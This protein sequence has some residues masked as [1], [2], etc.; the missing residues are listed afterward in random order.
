M[1]GISHEIKCAN[2]KHVL[3]VPVL[4]PCSHS[5]C[6]KHTIATEEPILCRICKKEHQ[7]PPPTGF[8]HITLDFGKEHRDAKH[9]CQHL[10]GLLTK[11][12]EIL[13]NPNNFTSKVID[14]L[15][16]VVKTKGKEMKTKI[17]KQMRQLICKLNDYSNECQIGLSPN[18]E[19][20][21]NLEKIQE[22]KEVTC[23]ELTKWLT[24]LNEIKFDQEGWNR[25]LSESKMAIE[26][27]EDEFDRFKRDILLGKRFEEIRAEIKYNFGELENNQLFDFK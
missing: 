25:I 18:T 1:F 12:D 11:I 7:I 9:S 21:K 13:K 27:F 5:I 22:E 26:R 20:A 19:N 23:N 6:K 4:L 15:K 14:H 8:P 2:C 24:T 3:T 16:N 10:D 17:D